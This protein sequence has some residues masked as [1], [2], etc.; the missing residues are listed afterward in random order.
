MQVPREIF[1]NLIKSNLIY[2]VI[3]LF[4]LIWHQTMFLFPFDFE[5]N[6]SKSNFFFASIV[7]PIWNSPYKEVSITGFHN[8][9]THQLPEYLILV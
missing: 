2:T 4:L 9:M 5:V 8:L 3:A 6:V 7:I 1:L